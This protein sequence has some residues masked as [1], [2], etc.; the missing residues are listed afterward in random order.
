MTFRIKLAS[1]SSFYKGIARKKY[2]TTVEFYELTG[3]AG[4]LKAT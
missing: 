4:G 3:L 1:L 2:P